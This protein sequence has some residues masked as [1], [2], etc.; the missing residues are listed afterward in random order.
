MEN[1]T[2]LVIEHDPLNTKLLRTL[3]TLGGY[4]TVE[5]V[6]AED[7]IRVVRECAP[8]CV[9]IDVR[10]PEMNGLRAIRTIK[11]DPALRAL[12]VI[13]VTPD[14]TDLRREAIQ[15][16]CDAY[17]TRPIASASFLETVSRLVD[18]PSAH[19][20]A[21]TA[22]VLVADDEP[23]IVDSLA[24]GLRSKGYD[25]IEASSGAEA[26]RK[27]AEQYP[28]LILLDVRMPDVNGYEVTRRLKGDIRT[29][30]IPII[31][32]TGLSD[33]HDKAIGLEAG[34]DEFLS[35]PVDQAELLVRISSILRLKQYREQ[36]RSRSMSGEKTVPE[37]ETGFVGSGEAP[38]ILLS[39]ANG[40]LDDLRDLLASKGFDVRAAG[41]S[42]DMGRAE[43]LAG[44]ALIILDAEGRGAEALEICRKLKQREETRFTPLVVLDPE[45]DPE[46][47][48]RFLSSGADDIMMPPVD[49]REILARVGRLLKRKGELESLRSRYRSALSAS[50]NDTLTGLFNQGYFK[51]FLILELKRSLRQ[52]HPT[53]LVIMDVDDF[54]SMNDSLGHLAGDQ[55]LGELAG[56]IR[57]C[58]REIDLP[59]RYGGEEFVVV[60]PYT[61]RDGAAVVAE[62]IRET[63]AAREFLQ[64]SSFPQVQV[65][66]SIGV[67]VG[68]EN[69][70]QPEELISA[71]DAL[72][73]KAKRAGKNRIATAAAP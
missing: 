41:H 1:R 10:L 32:V 40:G 45:N 53:S 38:R 56:R 5:A 33:S 43:G 44:A 50:T 66:V 14:T 18:M 8:D 20:P 48:V 62:R 29:L 27:A 71:A 6:N 26:V 3:L 54:K 65:T 73:Y 69:G 70:S 55:I 30:H 67:A 58:I 37:G 17:I 51:R 31:L 7:G 28:D 68:P 42:E 35:K 12:P 4:L 24:L 72:L 21:G 2:V 25:V 61:G 34:A 23:M 39:S 47:R 13:A 15:A 52:N 22:R 36:L 46:S 63:I 57:S 49:A 60:L 16:G 9:I 64:G 59:A 11:E 19:A